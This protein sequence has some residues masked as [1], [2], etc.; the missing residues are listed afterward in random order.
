M[1]ANLQHGKKVQGANLI[2]CFVLFLLKHNN[3]NF[4]SYRQP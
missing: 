2:S 3:H 4:K 1:D